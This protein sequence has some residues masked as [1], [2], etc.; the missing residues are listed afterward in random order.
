MMVRLI[1]NFI[2]VVLTSITL[3]NNGTNNI[4]VTIKLNRLYQGIEEDYIIRTEKL[5]KI[6]SDKIKYFTY[7]K[8]NDDKIRID[9]DEK[10]FKF[11]LN[12][13]DFAYIGRGTN[14]RLG[15]VD[16]IEIKTGDEI[17]IIDPKD[18]GEF[19]LKKSGLMK[20]VGIRVIE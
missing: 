10:K 3:I 19:E 12:S 11:K 15:I 18:A 13:G 8:M 5:E 4:E 16:K 7:E 20:L 14:A 2:L 6:N 1:R 17:K 9:K